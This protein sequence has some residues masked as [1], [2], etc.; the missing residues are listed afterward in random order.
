MATAS[1]VSTAKPKVGGALYRAPKGTTL[2]TDAKTALA[3]TFVAM[4]YSST[5]G[6]SNASSIETGE[7]KAWGG[8]T[9]QT[10]QTSKSDTF[11]LTLIEARNAEVL[12]T[13][14]GEGN[15]T[16]A[17]G[18]TTV[19]VTAEERID[20]VWAL[21]MILS[22]GYLKRIVIPLGKVTEVGEVTYKDDDVIA[23][24]ITI[25]AK[26]DTNGVYHYE[27]IEAAPANG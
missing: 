6:M 5:D 9:V 10:T 18:L 27:Y 2:P 8:D 13:V 22:D 12:K 14:H 24:E 21:D 26:P 4:G 3:N 16:V 15:V 20:Y 19:K 23:Y 11:K 25:T 7:V 1:N 17:D